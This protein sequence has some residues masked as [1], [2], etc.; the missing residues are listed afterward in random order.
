M[1]GSPAIPAPLPLNYGYFRLG[2][3]VGLRGAL[4]GVTG[5]QG[6]VQ[7]HKK[8]SHPAPNTRYPLP[9]IAAWFK[10][11]CC[12]CTRRRTSLMAQTV[13]HLST[14]RENP[15]QSL[16][17]EDPLEKER[18]I[19]SS[20]IAWKIPWTEEPGRLQSTGS[21]RIGHDWATA[22]SL[23]GTQVQPLGREVRF[24]VPCCTAIPGE[25]SKIPRALLHSQKL[26]E[27]KSTEDGQ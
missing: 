14:M 11:S 27:K 17:W 10:W 2:Q 12:Q 16:G 5:G 9:A 21:E 6:R 8:A 25:G 23:S 13:K 24:P 18:A 4:Q 20:T 26:K 1:Q 7:K 3:R 15:V 22:L 19:H